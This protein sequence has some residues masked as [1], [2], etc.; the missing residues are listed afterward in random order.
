MIVVD[1]SVVVAALMADGST[2]H[3]LLQTQAR[4][5]APPMIQ[6]EVKRAFD[7]VARKSTTDARKLRRVLEAV[8]SHIDIVPP[9]AYAH[10]RPDAQDACKVAQAWDDDEYVAL[11]MALQAPIWTL[12]RDF[13]RVA[14]IEVVVGRDFEE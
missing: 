11:A 7:R 13:E 5:I 1:A 14:G 3:A 4:L 6:A 12:D 10:A 8:W 2:R 9:K